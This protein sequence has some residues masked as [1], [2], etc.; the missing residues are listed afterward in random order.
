MDQPWH[1]TWFDTKYYHLLY[2]N[3]DDS[4]AQFFINTLAQKYHLQKGDRILDLACGKGRHS[5][6]LATFGCDVVGI[7]SSKNSIEEALLKSKSLLQ[8]EHLAFKVEDM[9]T[10][11][12]D[13]P[14]DYI[15]NLFT[16][17]GYFDDFKDNAKVLD[18]VYD[19][20][21]SGGLFLMDYLNSE[22]VRNSPNESYSKEIQGVIFN[23]KKEVIDSKVIKQIHIIDPIQHVEH[24][25]FERVHLFQSGELQQM[26]EDASLDLV[27]VF[28][29]YNLASYHTSSPRQIL[30]ARKK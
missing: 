9:R 30:I 17:F 10:F 23:I 14:F 18:R 8:N 7:D 27:G 12:F 25:Y 29:D 6:Q 21:K 15:F 22:L 24:T 5:F 4:E 3:R 26:I 16:S 2:Q 28:G 1:Q 19:N 11:H 13:S 20:L